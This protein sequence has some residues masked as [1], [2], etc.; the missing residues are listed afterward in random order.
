MGPPPVIYDDDD[1]YWEE[2]WVYSRFA[3][4]WLVVCLVCLLIL[5]WLTFW[6]Q[7]G[8]IKNQ[9]DGVPRYFV[10]DVVDEDDNEAGMPK[11]LRN[12]RIAAVF[13]GIIG[14]IV[15]FLAYFLRPKPAIRKALGAV[16][17]LLLLVAA[18][19]AWI[20]FAIALDNYKDAVQC[21]YL[22]RITR[23]KCRSREHVAIAA[24]TIDA[25]VG[26]FA[27]VAGVL[28][29]INSLKGH[30]KLAARNWEEEQLDLRNE[31]PKERRPA[32]MIMR[33][34]SY[35]RK[36][37][38]GLALFFTLLFLVAMLVLLLILHEDRE[39]ELLMG[40]RGRAHR[41]LN[42]HTTGAYYEHYTG[43]PYEHSGWPTVN[44]RIRYAAVAVGIVT[45]LLNFLPF[46]ARAI[47]ILFAF[48]Y[49]CAA[50]LCIIAFGWDVHTLRWVGKLPCPERILGELVECRIAPY[51][52]TCVMDFITALVLIIYLLVEFTFG[53][54]RQGKVYEY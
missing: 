37:L 42:P 19:L 23:A 22:Y 53:A 47:A 36:W 43:G 51:V 32:E 31:A 41:G 15:G 44:T 11:N 18:I 50:A 38:T 17:F 20:A 14:V 13:I 25:C 6:Q 3:L 9:W 54:K 4:P 28:V 2:N 48:L 45:V 34:V 52:A 27:L 12:L 30:W 39:K 7:T 26:L 46:R 24:I 33:N 29:L 1:D 21:P 5:F 10:R 35:V 16:S 49:F 40:A 8:N